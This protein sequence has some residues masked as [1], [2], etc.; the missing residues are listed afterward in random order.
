MNYII[1]A[2]FSFQSFIFMIGRFLRWLN[3]MREY[4]WLDF[5]ISIENRT[6]RKSL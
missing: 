2:I 6:Y 3:I 5:A 4:M 1:F